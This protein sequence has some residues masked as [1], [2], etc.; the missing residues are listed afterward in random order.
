MMLIMMIVVIRIVIMMIV[1]IV[2]GY[3]SSALTRPR[4]GRGDVDWADEPSG[5]R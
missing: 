1:I 2:I 3:C 4:K 5:T